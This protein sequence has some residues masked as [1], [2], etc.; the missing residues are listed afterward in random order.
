MVVA[1]ADKSFAQGNITELEADWLLYKAI[2]ESAWPR[3]SSPSFSDIIFAPKTFGYN[4][5]ADWNGP[6]ILKAPRP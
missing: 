5:P 4:V 1:N 3:G 6:I 2:V